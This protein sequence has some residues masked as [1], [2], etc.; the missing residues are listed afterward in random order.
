[1]T[2]SLAEAEQVVRSGARAADDRGLKV[3]LAVV[4]LHGD[5]VS[6]ARLDGARHFTA[7]AAH[8]KALV[9]A[10]L[11]APSGDY[12]EVAQLQVFQ[13][14]NR[15]HQDRMVFWQGAVP[16]RRSGAHVGA[17]GVA[18]A[19]SDEDEEIARAAAAAL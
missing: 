4:D 3:S 1:M 10:L 6:L 7:N 15:A 14:L 5:L 19:A 9:S 11:A 17:I 2:I 16:L 13:S 12:S 8:G 18:G